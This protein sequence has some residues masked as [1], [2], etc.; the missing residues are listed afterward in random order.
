MTTVVSM[1]NYA[2]LLRLF[3]MTTVVSMLNYAQLLR[4]QNDNCGQYA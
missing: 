3:R 4:L 1:L 2:Q